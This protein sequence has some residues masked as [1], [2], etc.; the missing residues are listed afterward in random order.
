MQYRS[1]YSRESEAKPTPDTSRYAR[2]RYRPIRR[3]WQILSPETTPSLEIP[4]GLF[5]LQCQRKRR[6]YS[7]TN[8]RSY[9][10]KPAATYATNRRQG[11]VRFRCTSKHKNIPP[12]QLEHLPTIVSAH[13]HELTFV[14]L[15]LLMLSRMYV[16]F[17]GRLMYS[18]YRWGALLFLSTVLKGLPH[19]AHFIAISFEISGLATNFRS[20]D[21]GIVPSSRGL[22]RFACW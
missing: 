10:Y 13:E 9:S 7:K 16:R 20:W 3:T 17:I 19:P 21:G 15:F 5:T 11:I 8:T 4:R 2:A 22:A 18:K 6:N 12:Q 1:E 14:Y